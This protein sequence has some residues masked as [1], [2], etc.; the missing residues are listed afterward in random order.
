MYLRLQNVGKQAIHGRLPGEVFAVLA[1]EDGSVVNHLFRKRVMDEE[2]DGVGALAILERT[3]DAPTDCVIIDGNGTAII[4]QQRPPQS[5]D[6]RPAPPP[7]ADPGLR[8]DLN[9]LAAR[10]AA[11]EKRPVPPD[12]TVAVKRVI[13]DQ[14][15][16]RGVLDDFMRRLVAIEDA[17]TSPAPAPAA[18]PAG[19]SWKD[20]LANAGGDDIVARIEHL[21]D[22]LADPAPLTPQQQRQAAADRIRGA[23]RSRLLDMVS[24]EIVHQL[25]MLAAHQ[26][27]TAKALLQSVRPDVDAFAAEIVAKREG[28]DG[29]REG[30]EWDTTVKLIS[31]RDRWLKALA[32]AADAA[33]D[34]TV[35][36]ALAEIGGIGAN[37]G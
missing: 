18:A 19:Y 37:G 20:V 2:R 9:Q 33:I 5:V 28:V 34:Q 17:A 31:A 21:E 11:L 36:S 7:P 15:A 16:V 25:A 13:D 3:E 29:A 12:L 22:K 26:D 1:N 6:A 10:V 4:P 27:A 14:T 32:A 35:S 24:G 30:S 23:V 8:D